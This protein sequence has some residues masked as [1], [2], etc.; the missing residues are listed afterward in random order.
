MPTRNIS[1]QRKAVYYA[2]IGLMV[3]GFLTFGSVFVTGAM[4]FGD[5][6]NF[7][8][9][10]RSSAMRGVVGMGLMIVGGILAAVGSRGLAGSGVVIDPEQA[11]KDLE[12]WSRM[13]GGVI[14][15][16]LDETGLVSAGKSDEA[17]ADLPFDE[18]LRR[19]Y[20]LYQDGILSE[21]E[22]QK[23]KAEILEKS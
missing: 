10:A 17:Q 3:V 23:E 11:R 15:D 2:G 4:N 21:E 14:K 1:P 9:R 12:P 8:A 7:E 13:A 19:L 5:F 6:S 18:K 16:A 22:Y 20:Q